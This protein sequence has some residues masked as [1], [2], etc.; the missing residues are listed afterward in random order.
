[1]EGFR[2]LSPLQIGRKP[3]GETYLYGRMGAVG[4]SA[5]IWDGVSGGNMT[6]RST[7]SQNYTLEDKDYKIV[8]LHAHFRIRDVGNTRSLSFR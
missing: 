5:V 6:P 4:L 3:S 1:M 2:T 8:S 7:S